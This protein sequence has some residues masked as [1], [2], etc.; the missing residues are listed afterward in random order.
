MTNRKELKMNNTVNK[1]RCSY[2]RIGGESFE[3]CKVDNDSA[4]V[5]NNSA[6]V[7]NGSMSFT[8]GCDYSWLKD[9][10]ECKGPVNRIWRR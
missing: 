8:Y 10:C 6:E 1:E 4:Q 2:A 3:N 7:D 5:D 9:K